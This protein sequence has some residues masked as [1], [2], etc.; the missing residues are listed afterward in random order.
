MSEDLEYLSFRCSIEQIIAPC[1]HLCLS[2]NIVRLV[3]VFMLR[4]FCCFLLF[5]ACEMFWKNL[6]ENSY[7]KAPK[8]RSI[9]EMLLKNKRVMAE[10]ITNTDKLQPTD[11][12]NL[13]SRQMD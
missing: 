4:V 13:L 2:L 11:L 1:S 12:L 10:K 7:T 6:V 9:S 3:M 8:C 5:N